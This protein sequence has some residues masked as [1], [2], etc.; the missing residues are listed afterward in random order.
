MILMKEW[1]LL[2]RLIA[3]IPTIAAMAYKYSLGQPFN[4]PQN[5]LSYAENFLT[6]VL[7]CT[8]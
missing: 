4:Y 6:Y 7:F 1:F 2:R 3:K 5:D 8:S